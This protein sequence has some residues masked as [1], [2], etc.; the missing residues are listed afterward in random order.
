[1]KVKTKLF[2]LFKQTISDSPIPLI[3]KNRSTIADSQICLLHI[4]WLKA[5]F[6]TTKPAPSAG[7]T[8]L[9]A[10]GDN[11]RTILRRI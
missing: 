2:S 11:F 10:E 9:R 4:F 1:M 8:F 3:S 6:R 5:I 7:F